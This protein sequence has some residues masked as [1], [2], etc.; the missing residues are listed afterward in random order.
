M[1]DGVNTPVEDG[2]EPDSEEEANEQ[3]L[4]ECEAMKAEGITIFA[5]TFDMDGDLT[6]LYQ[7]CTTV[8]EYQFDAETEF[9]LE[10]VFGII[11]D[12]VITGNARLVF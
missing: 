3:L 11:G 7:Q 5:V 12:L 1:T 6:D 10:Q 8:P 4:R 9:E 2:E